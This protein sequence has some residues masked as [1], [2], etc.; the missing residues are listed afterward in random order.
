MQHFLGNDN[1]GLMVSKQV[2]ADRT[3][4]H[5]FVHQAI[6][7]SCLVSNKTGE[8]GYSFPLFKKVKDKFESNLSTALC[9][10]LENHLQRKISDLTNGPP[11]SLSPYDVFDYVYGILHA[12]NYRKKYFNLLTSGFPKIPYPKSLEMFQKIVSLGKELRELH[13]MRK[14]LPPQTLFKGDGTNRITKVISPNS[15]TSNG[16]VWINNT[17]YFCEIP[18]AAWEMKIGS[19]RVTQKWL[20]D[21]KRTQ[22]PLGKADIAHYLQ[23][24]EI[25]GETHRIIQQ[26]D[27]AYQ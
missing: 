25:L 10:Q 1:I 19:Y 22:S 20:N 18:K 9:A 24:V 14:H 15:R 8:I 6:A 11:V 2:K 16:M 26:L 13:L 7:E 4:Q 3:Y 21:K 5:V 27:L 23:I 12:T 17:Q